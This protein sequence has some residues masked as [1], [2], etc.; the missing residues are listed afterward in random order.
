M[1]S[2]HLNPHVFPN[3]RGGAVGITLRDYF[4]AYALSGLLSRER[5]SG[6]EAASLAYAYADALLEARAPHEEHTPTFVP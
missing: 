6:E 4:A 3:P 2:Q 5:L 1:N